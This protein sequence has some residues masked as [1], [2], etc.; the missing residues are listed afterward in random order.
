MRE[1]RGAAAIELSRKF[2]V[3]RTTDRYWEIIENATT[4][5]P[6]AMASRAEA[7]LAAASKRI[8]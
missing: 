1:A 7:H 4:S 8:S 2:S 5:R 3:E 6:K